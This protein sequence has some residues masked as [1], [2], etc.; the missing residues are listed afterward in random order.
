M[1][2][3]KKTSL[4]IDICLGTAIE[5]KVVTVELPAGAT[6]HQ[7]VLASGLL[8]EAE[9]KKHRFGLFGQFKSLETLLHNHDRVEIYFPLQI[10]PKVA[11][12]ERVKQTRTADAIERR[13]WH[14]QKTD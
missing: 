10:D 9:I 12:M 13:K 14:Q 1:T 5:P 3:P 6:L 7:A 8:P 2:A 4:T 11:R